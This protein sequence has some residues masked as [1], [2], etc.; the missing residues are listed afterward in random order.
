[1]TAVAETP[2]FV[3]VADAAALDAAARVWASREALAL[4]TEFVRERTFFQKLGLVQVGDGE[5]IWLV[6]PLACGELAP[7]ARVLE[8][9]SVLKVLHSGSEDLEVFH[10]R[11]GTQPAP[12]FDTQI[13]A[14]L[15]GLPP[16]L[17]YARLVQE[18]LGVELFKGET[19]TDW[20]RRP[21]SEAQLL[22]ASEDVAYLVPL[23]RQLQER[24]DT[25]G[26]YG[27][28][29][30]DSAEL[31]DPGRYDGEA[32]RPLRLR[33]AARF[34]RRQM[35]TARALALWREA[36]ARRRDVPRSFVLKDD[37]LAQLVARR[38]QSLRDL[39]R[40]P[41]YDAR[42]GARDGGYWLEIL[43]RTAETS[44]D[45]LPPMPWRLADH[46]AARDAESALRE[47]V[48]ARAAELGVEPEVLASRRALEAVLKSAWAGESELPGALSGWRRDAIGED[49]WR[50]AREAARDASG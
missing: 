46:A 23:Y 44:D 4:D 39:Q 21:L 7:L 6:D 17:G 32:E 40:L 27:W 41:A 1:M 36:E 47:R 34:D 14:G 10:H 9:P 28:A 15:A 33:A 29:I 43:R 11:L 19:R 3:L 37:L 16:S 49:L 24:L 35:Q 50:A 8:Q 5:R 25:L 20:L 42:Q 26:R 38:P 31:G 12:L 2:A 22:Y 30:E 18:L 45:E 48:R 13:A